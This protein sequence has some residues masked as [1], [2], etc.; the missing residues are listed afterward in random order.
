MQLVFEFDEY[1]EIVDVLN[2]RCHR[3]AEHTE[4]ITDLQLCV[5]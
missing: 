5:L 4:K 3:E 2:A 1:Q